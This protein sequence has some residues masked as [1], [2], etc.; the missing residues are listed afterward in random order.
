MRVALVHDWLTGMRGGEKCLEVLCEIFPD[1]PI[2]T[3]VH[4]QGRVSPAIEAHAIHTSFIQS[5]PGARTKHQPYL[6]LFPSA[7]ERFDLS[8][9][10]LVV[11]TSHCVA[12]GARVRS[13]AVHVCFCHTPMRYVWDQYDAYWGATVA[14]PF[15][16][17]VMPVLATYLRMWDVTTTPRVTHFLTNSRNVE[18]R[19]R[20]TYGRESEVLGMWI[21]TA[22]FRPPPANARRDDVDL[23]VSALVPYKRIDLAVLAANHLRRELVIIGTGPEEKR[24]RALAGPTV[25]FLGWTSDDEIVAWMQ[26]ARALVFPGEEDFGLVPLESIACACP[27]VAYGRGGALE[28]VTDGVTGVH[29]REQ[30]VRALCEGLQRVDRVSI[31]AATAARHVAPFTRAVFR[32]RMEEAIARV[33]RSPVRAAADV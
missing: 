18:R 27:V 22:R 9:Y 3:L 25:S 29:V 6:A 2:Y 28:T 33:A 8:A 11:S 13:D 20:A 31:D 16:R 14:S 19:I 5:L 1:A 10:D 23:V 32:R 12:K 24:L 7:I 15:T 4:R 17:L 26:R 21:D 30:T